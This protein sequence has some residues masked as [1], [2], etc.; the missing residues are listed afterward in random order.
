MSG[1]EEWTRLQLSEAVR[2]RKIDITG[3]RNFMLA[4]QFLFVKEQGEDDDVMSNDAS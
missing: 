3:E 4:P 2:K 1:V